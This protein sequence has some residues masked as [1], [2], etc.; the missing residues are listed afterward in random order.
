MTQA[1]A[2]TY[3][4]GTGE[5]NDP[6]QIATVQDLIDLRNEFSDYDKHFNMT[7]DIDLSGYWF[8]KAVIA[9]DTDSSYTD[10]DSPFT[11]VF[12]GQGHTIS[13]LRIGGNSF[14]GLFGQLDQYAIVRNLGLIDVRIEGTSWYKSGVEWKS[15]RVGALVGGAYNHSA[16]S[17]CYSTGIV[18]GGNYVGGLIGHIDNQCMVLNC[19]S[20]CTVTGNNYVGGFGGNSWNNA[21]IINSYCNGGVTGNEYVGGFMGNIINCI[22]SN[23]FWDMQTSGLDTSATGLGL[24]TEQMC[25]VNSFLNA[26]WDCTQEVSNG[27]SDIWHLQDNTSPVLS[28]F[29]DIL[30]NEPNGIGTED[31]PYLIAEVN[32]LCFVALHPAASYRLVASLD[33]SGMTWAVAPIPWFWGTFDGNEHVISNLNIQGDRYLGLFGKLNTNA[34]VS[35]LGLDVVD[36]N[37]AGSPVGGLAGYN[38]GRVFLCYSSGTVMGSDKVGGL[39]GRN[40]SG[41]VFNCYTTGSVTGYDSTGGLIGHGDSETGS[42]DPVVKY[43]GSVTGCYSDATVIGNN[44]VGGLIG[45]TQSI[46]SNCYSAGLVTGYRRVGGFVGAYYNKIFNCYST[47]TVSESELSGGFAGKKSW[48]KGEVINSFWDK[49]T[50]G[51]K[52]SDGGIGLTTSQMQDINTY[53]DAGW[54]FVSEA[55]N[56]TDDIWFMP[57]NDYPQLVQ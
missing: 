3:S 28:V 37:G 17:N 5:P 25:D 43:V 44:A 8:M 34:V 32:E 18:K 46:V 20:T 31:D 13:N 47:S 22:S 39:I 48:F 9:W 1:Q 24:T 23:C 12:D 42:Q 15:Y 33:L 50:S 41:D 51:I 27:V 11:G 10:Q 57:K 40:D 35:R 16:V 6:Y 55:V 53:L 26:G 49:Q 30:L 45:S 2:G 14:L 36:V 56:G 52:E 54:D 21:S 29:S 38:S 19:Y 7:A 4:G